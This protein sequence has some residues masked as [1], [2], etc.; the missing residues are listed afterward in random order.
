[1][2]KNR[3]TV[4]ILLLVAAIFLSFQCTKKYDTDEPQSSFVWSFQNN[5]YAAT[6]DTAYTQGFGLSPFYIVA[7]SGT[8]FV[9]NF[10]RKIDFTLTSFNPGSYTISLSTNKLH[11]IDDAGF[12]W[13]G[14]S[15]TLNI[16]SNVN[17]RMSGNF[18]AMMNGPSS[19]IPISG[20][21]DH[22]PVKP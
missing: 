18:T 16:T 2:K 6:L 12:N 20:N 11:Y 14:I 22:V 15:G 9:T 10:N 4:S 1:M 7:I 5:T 21:F 8:H 17:N 19:N 3:I 13:D